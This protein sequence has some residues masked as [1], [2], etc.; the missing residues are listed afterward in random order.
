MTNGV[1]GKWSGGVNKYCT[2]TQHSSAIAIVNATANA[3]T[4]TSNI[5]KPNPDTEP[6]DLLGC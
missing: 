5:F 2:S 4:V 1:I 6:D 3:I